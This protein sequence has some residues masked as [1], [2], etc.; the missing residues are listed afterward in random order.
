[1]AVALT[2][3]WHIPPVKRLAMDHTDAALLPDILGELADL[4]GVI[5]RTQLQGAALLNELHRRSQCGMPLIRGRNSATLARYTSQH[6][7]FEHWF[8][9]P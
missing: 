5:V 8:L 9:Q 7:R 1:M 3:S 4:C 2:Q 6:C